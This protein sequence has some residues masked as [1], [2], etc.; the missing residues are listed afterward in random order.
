MTIVM[1]NP[2]QKGKSGNT[3]Y[4]ACGDF[5]NHRSAAVCWYGFGLDVIPVLRGTKMTAVKWDPWLDNLGLESICNHWDTHPD[6]ELGFI[7]GDD[8]IVFDADSPEAIAA[9]AQI[10]E[11]F[12]ITPNLII[13]TTKG[14][15]HFFRRAADTFCKSDSHSTEKHP[16]RIDVKTGR[17][18]VVLP[19]STGKTVLIGEV[20]DEE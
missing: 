20:F 15:H 8:M 10:E 5:T 12:D 13:Q 16:A 4:S 1:S 17:A 7:V 9:L 3:K 19:P 14:Q 6:H 2:R 18:L 11:A